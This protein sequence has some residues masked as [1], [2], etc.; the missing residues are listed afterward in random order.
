MWYK[1]SKGEIMPVATHRSAGP[2]VV[3]DPTSTLVAAA[4]KMAPQILANPSLSHADKVEYIR[5]E[6]MHARHDAGTRTALRELLAGLPL[7]RPTDTQAWRR[8]L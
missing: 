2:L 3:Y 4:Q 5:G 6:L 8:T 7:C 1:L